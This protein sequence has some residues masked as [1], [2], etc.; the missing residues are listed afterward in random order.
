MAKL[1]AEHLYAEGLKSKYV[2]HFI[3][4]LHFTGCLIGLCNEVFT[5][6][7]SVLMRL[8]AGEVLDSL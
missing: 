2:K 8:S 5:Q 6:S 4:T 3:A 7:A 1:I